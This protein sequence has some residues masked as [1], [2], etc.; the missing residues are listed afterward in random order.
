MDFKE[1]GNDSQSVSPLKEKYMVVMLML[2]QSFQFK[3]NKVKEMFC[4]GT[5]P[6]QTCKPEGRGPNIDNT[7]LRIS[8]SLMERE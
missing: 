2:N 8:H 5:S 1:L 4:T 7:L 6:I 3:I